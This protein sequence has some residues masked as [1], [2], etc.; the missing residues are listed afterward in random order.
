MICLWDCNFLTSSAQCVPIFEILYYK[1]YWRFYD[2]K[3]KHPSQN[4]QITKF[5]FHILEG[6][7]HNKIDFTAPSFEMM[8]EYTN[9]FH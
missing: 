9:S 7:I 5:P 3:I 2:E 6:R 4:M 1:Q 8:V